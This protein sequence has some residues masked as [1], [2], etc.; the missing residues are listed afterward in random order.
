MDTIH[1]GG[2]VSHLR[3]HG[4][5]QVPDTLLMLN[6]DIEIADQNDAAIGADALLATAEFPG[7]HES[8]HDVYTIL[9]IKGDTG[10][11]IKTDYI[12]LA[13]QPTPTGRVVDK[14]LGDRCLTAGNQMRIRRNLLEE[15]AF[16]SSPR[17]EFHQIVVT[18]N[19][20]NH[21]QHQGITLSLRQSS[22]FYP[23]RTKQEYLPF[24]SGKC[25]T[26]L[27]Q[28]VEYIPFR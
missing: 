6:I 25:F 26:G 1:E 11:L 12:V 10:N 18:L 17:A 23:Y 20:G 5:E 8:L 9:L 15:M 16:A 2:V 22:R 27:G 3:R 7:L 28:V 13:D 19:K 21:P 14:H 24:F 4:T